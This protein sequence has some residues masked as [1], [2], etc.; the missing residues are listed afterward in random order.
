MC[1]SPHPVRA[2][3]PIQMFHSV[4][5]PVI[6]MPQNLF[7]TSPFLNTISVFLTRMPPLPTD[8]LPV[9]AVTSCH[10]THRP[11]LYQQL[12]DSAKCAAAKTL[13]LVINYD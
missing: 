6:H 13:T 7:R 9:C 4:C 5:D 1:A 3:P 8:A 11:E 12:L 2:D 10:Y